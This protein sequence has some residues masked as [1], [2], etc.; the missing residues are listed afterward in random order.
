[1]W[2]SLFL[3]VSTLNLLLPLSA[4][5]QQKKEAENTPVARLTQTFEKERTN[6]HVPGMAIVVV[7]DD[8]VVLSQGFGL[9]DVENKKP[10]TPETL[11]AIGSATKAFTATLIALL[12]DEG[13]MQWEDP[14]TR[15]LPTFQLPIDSEEDDASVT[16]RDLLAHRT[17][18]TRMGILWAGGD[19]SRK[20]ILQ[21]AIKAEPWAPFRKE[22]LYSN[23]MYLAAGEAAGTAGES[24]WDALVHQRL[25]QP[26]GMND[27]STTLAA[28]EGDAR[29][30]LG[31][32][33]KESPTAIPMRNLD[34]IGPA[35]SINSNITDMAAWLRLLLKRGEF[36]GT[37]L[38][39]EKNL[40]ETW[41]RQNA[42]GGGMSYGLGWMRQKIDGKRLIEHGGNIDGFSAQV[43]IFIDDGLGFALLTN[44]TATPMQAL[45]N[46]L[47]H[48]AF[49]APE[50]PNPVDGEPN[51]ETYT[52]N[53]EAN[54]AAFKEAI[55]KVTAEEGTLRINIPGQTNYE[56]RPPN[57]E[58]KWFFKV[59]DAI[60]ISFQRNE[61][62]VVSGL[63]L[64]QAGLTFDAPKEGM[65][66]AIDEDSVQPYLG[67]Y[68]ANFG[69]FK[70]DRF[71]VLIH[72][73]RLAVDVPGQTIYELK[74][75][76]ESGKRFFAA[77]SEIAV[78]FDEGPDGTVTGMKLYQGGQ[79]YEAPKIS[80]EKNQKTL[81][82][83]PN[84]EALL[85]LRETAKRAR[86]FDR[87][88][89]LRIQ[90]HIRMIHAGVEGT[91]D[92]QVKGRK[93][94]SV[95]R[96]GRFGNQ[97][98]SLDGDKG[99]SESSFSPTS[100][101]EGP[102]FHM[103][104]L[105]D[106]A[107]LFGDWRRFFDPITVLR[108]DTVQGRDAWVLKLEKEEMEP[109]IATID[110]STGDLLHTA[111]QF[112]VPGIEGMSLPT[113]VTYSDHR[114]VRGIRLPWKQ[115]RKDEA[116]GTMESRILELNPEPVPE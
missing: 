71:E 100:E 45:S 85:A 9:A 91:T 24:T 29:L 34:T 55:F 21:T 53:Y 68:E 99:T 108:K 14:V 52:G 69:P 31:Y 106:P 104:R 96:F 12:V 2:R 20:E 5:A 78:S 98:T 26:L 1:M 22:F 116:T 60:A 84:L 87:L 110:A 50:P 66:K 51:L 88:K 112:P 62:G 70:D 74:E 33:G 38:I 81:A 79:T 89:S 15:H 77:T 93:L 92:L 44:V 47:V 48:D 23:V 4:P 54:F 111:F 76:D 80:D 41:K 90:S 19:V 35:G 43:G 86:S 32:D 73:G 107:V 40:N 56:L 7:K 25:F 105:A 64:H 42:I 103:A 3:T 6:H 109:V 27:S 10:V 97:K 37:R 13:K 18:F 28:V 113:E 115:T 49:L 67:H 57:E 11:F 36:N 65:R 75:P 61:A 8:E 72:N 16:L 83:R 63:Q 30:S 46:R 59:T 94:E 39:S 82:G 17:G 101:L 102:T 58:G 114:T 95:T